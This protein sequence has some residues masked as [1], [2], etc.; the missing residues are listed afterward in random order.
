METFFVNYLHLASFKEV[1]P[2]LSIIICNTIAIVTIN[3]IDS[4]KQQWRGITLKCN[5]VSMTAGNE[6]KFFKKSSNQCSTRKM[7][8]WGA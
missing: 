8:L 6:G 2:L 1:R 7:I 3:V 4:K 5:R